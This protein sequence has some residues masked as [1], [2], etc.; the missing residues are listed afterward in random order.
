LVPIII[1]DPLLLPLEEKVRNGERLTRE[2]GLI[3]YQTRDLPGL[4]QMA[5]AA[6]LRRNG[7]AVYFAVN[8]KIE[9]SNI[10]ALNCRFCAF[11]AAA[12]QGGAFS[13]EIPQIL[14]SIPPDTREIHLTGSLNP[15]RPFQYYLDLLAAIRER[16]PRVGIKAFTAVEIDYFHRRFRMPLAEVL[17]RLKQAGVMSLPGGGAEIFSERVRRLICPRKMGA[18]RWL[19]IHRLAHKMGLPT[20]ATMLYGHLETLEERVDHLLQLRRLQE[21]TGGFL[22]FVPLPFQPGKGKLPLAAPGTGGVEDLKTIAV[23]RLLLDNFP[24]IKAYWVMLTPD[25]ATLGLH[26]GADDLDGIVGGEKIAHAAGAVSPLALTRQTIKNMIRQARRVG[27]ER[28]IHYLPEKIE[29]KD[30]IGKIPYLNSVP[31]YHH[32]PREPFPLVPLVPRHLGVFSRRGQVAGGIYSLLDYWQEEENLTLLPYG[33]AAVGEVQSVLLFSR[34]PWEKLA[35]KPIG[36]TDDT[37]TSIEL[38]RVLLRGKYGIT[39]PFSRIA[40]GEHPHEN[41]EALLLIGNEALVMRKRGLPGFPRVYDLALEW[42]NWRG[43]PFVFAVWACRRDWPTRKARL[44]EDHIAQALSRAEGELGELAAAYGRPLGLAAA[45][46]H[47]YL[48]SFRYRL[49][50][51]ERAAMASFRELLGA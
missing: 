33:I 10:C 14:A 50:P 44:L 20:N 43:L 49:G 22:S 8:Q 6:N 47:H 31:F 3:L 30:V 21:E 23:S 18:G 35:G 51:E 42:R 11:S 1:R 5:A 48:R 28:D 24:H 39:A 26:F 9:P 4:G 32:F 40:P 41:R 45:E 7:D 46:A 38:L 37:A 29:G 16:F 17:T 36:I 2:D 12:R 19:A 13:L 27:V 15:D 25:A 34:V